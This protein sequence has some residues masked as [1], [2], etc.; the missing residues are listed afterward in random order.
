MSDP[1]AD[2]LALWCPNCHT[3]PNPQTAVDVLRDCCPRCWT[4]YGRA[5]PMRAEADPVCK[6]CQQHA[7]MPCANTDA[8]SGCRRFNT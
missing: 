7:P 8:A 2:G 5:I 4:K 6:L 3:Y 1:N